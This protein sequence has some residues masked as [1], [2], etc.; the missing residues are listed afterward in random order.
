MKTAFYLTRNLNDAQ[1]VAQEVY[2][3]IFRYLPSVQRE[4][5][6]GWIYRTTVNAAY[7]FHRKHRLLKPLRRIF[8]AAPRADSIGA[9]ELRG[10]LIESLEQ[11]SFRE[12][13]AFILRELQELETADVA[14]A[15][16]C[17][18]VTVRGYVHSARKKLQKRLVDFREDP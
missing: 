7:D 8:S 5:L 4:K 17:T 16:G 10:R 18:E 2:I 3:K 6:A 15:L 9:N 14:A 12:R 11:L 13:A 1:D